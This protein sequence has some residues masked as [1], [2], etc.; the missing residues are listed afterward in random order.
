MFDVKETIIFKMFDESPRFR[1]EY[2]ETELGKDEE[3]FIQICKNY[4]LNLI[5]DVYLKQINVESFNSKKRLKFKN[6][7]LIIIKKLKVFN[8]LK[9]HLIE[10]SKEVTDIDVTF[11]KYF[12]DDYHEIIDHDLSYQIIFKVVER[13]FRQYDEQNRN[14]EK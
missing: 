7:E 11:T 12:D 10:A 6:Q 1:R 13:Y 14:R 2:I 5:S 3:V 9:H 8:C 4:K